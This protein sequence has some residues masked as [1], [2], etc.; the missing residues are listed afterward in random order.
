LSASHAI[1]AQFFRRRVILAQTN[2]GA[3]NSFATTWYRNVQ[4]KAQ[5]GLAKF[6]SCR[7]ESLG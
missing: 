7:L 4:H 3:Q 1:A 2:G 6:A 5:I